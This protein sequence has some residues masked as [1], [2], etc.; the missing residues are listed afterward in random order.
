MTTTAPSTSSEPSAASAPANDAPAAARRPVGPGLQAL[1]FAAVFVVF[2]LIPLGLVAMVSFWDFNEYALLPTFTLRNYAKLWEGCGHLNE[3]GDLCVTASTYL[4]TLRFAL[5]TWVLTLVLGFALAYFLAFHVRSAAVQTL[6][7]VICTV[8]FWTSNVIRMISWI[9][10]L[11]RNGLVNQTLQAMHLI[12]QPQDWLL[13]SNFSVLLAYVHLYTMFMIVPIFNS[14]MRIDRALLEAARD[15]GATAWQTLW[16]VIVPLSRSG[17]LIGSIFI[18]TIVM[19]DFVTVGVM[20]GQQIASVGKMIQVQTSYLQFPL[21]AANAVVLLLTV[22]MIIW[23][24]TRVVDIRK[25]L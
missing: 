12:D 23:G 11:G 2:F 6:L 19:G 10:L 4:S 5:G 24:L 8:P 13:Y 1:P 25:E 22:L 16:H 3:Y 20:G 18:L 15:A 9:P 21:A 14:M 7:F 17:I